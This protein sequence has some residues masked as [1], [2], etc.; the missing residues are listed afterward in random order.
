MRTELAR[1]AFNR[2]LAALP[3]IASGCA[4]DRAKHVAGR[5]WHHTAN[6]FRNPEG[7]LAQGGDFGD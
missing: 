3:M 2:G 7:S 6:G 5:P 1:R 4:G